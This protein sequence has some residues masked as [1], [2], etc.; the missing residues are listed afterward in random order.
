MV[1]LFVFL[2]RCKKIRIVDEEE[3]CL[4]DKGKCLWMGERVLK[5]EVVDME[6]GV[7]KMFGLVV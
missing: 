5:G 7:I 1:D 6:D 2:L 4:W 3:R